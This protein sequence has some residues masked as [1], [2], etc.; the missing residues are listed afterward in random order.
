[1]KKAVLARSG[2]RLKYLARPERFE[3]PTV[4]FEVRCSIR[5]SYGRAVTHY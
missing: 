1:M 3:R 4:G 2:N 5:L